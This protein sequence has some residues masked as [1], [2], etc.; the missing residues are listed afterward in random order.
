M[1]S[2]QQPLQHENF[3]RDES[4]APK[5]VPLGCSECLAMPS[6]I[7]GRTIESDSI[8]HAHGSILHHATCVTVF[9]TV[10]YHGSLHASQDVASLRGR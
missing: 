10:L 6:T 8:M 2:V 4:F 9:P 3:F 1:E 7:S 5:N